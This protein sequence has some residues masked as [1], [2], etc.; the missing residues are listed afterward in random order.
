MNTFESLQKLLKVCEHSGKYLD[1]VSLLSFA[2]FNKKDFQKK[3]KNYID[4]CS[5]V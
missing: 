4:S 5:A 2:K 1:L 3:I